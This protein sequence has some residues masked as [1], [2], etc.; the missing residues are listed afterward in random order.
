MGRGLGDITDG[1]AD[2]MNLG[3]LDLIGYRVA[4]DSKH[5]ER[6]AADAARNGRLE[7]RQR[8]ASRSVSIEGRQIALSPGV[9]EKIGSAV[10][11]STRLLHTGHTALVVV[12]E[13]ATLSEL[14]AAA[15]KYLRALS[16]A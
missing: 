7:V 14:I 3:D 11:V 5:D 16:A 6:R 1:E 8:H 2:V 12:P 13:D 15:V 10:C 9:D 4:A